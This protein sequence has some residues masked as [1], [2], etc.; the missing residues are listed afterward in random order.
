MSCSVTTAAPVGGGS[1]FW[2]SRRGSDGNRHDRCRCR[3]G[4]HRFLGVALIEND[5][6]HP[7]NREMAEEDGE[8]L[9]GSMA[10][11]ARTVPVVISCT[12]ESPGRS[13]SGTSVFAVRRSDDLLN[14]NELESQLGNAFHEPVKR[15]IVANLA[16]HDRRALHL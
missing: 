12:A 2:R 14:R 7:G 9:R 8:R 3:F 15:R 13:E 6:D 16:G 1:G 11:W 5:D 10:V 4:G